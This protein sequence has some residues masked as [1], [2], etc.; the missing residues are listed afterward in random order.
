MRDAQHERRLRDIES[1]ANN[2]RIGWKDHGL[3]RDVVTGLRRIE[4]LANLNE[5]P[6]GYGDIPRAKEKP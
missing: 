1:L 2:L 5:M 6:F 4:E 3:P